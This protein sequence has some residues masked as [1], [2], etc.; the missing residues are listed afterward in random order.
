LF[1]NAAALKALKEG[2]D[3]GI[4][5]YERFL[6]DANADEE[7]KNLAR[8]QLIPQGRSHIPILDRLIALQK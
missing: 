8:S 1:G 2:E 5:E 4:K 3:H 7:C 6:E